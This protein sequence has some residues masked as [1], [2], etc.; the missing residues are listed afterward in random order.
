MYYLKSRDSFEPR[1]A[2]EKWVAVHGTEISPVY[3]F[4]GEGVSRKAMSKAA[5]YNKVEKSY[6]RAYVLC[7]TPMWSALHTPN[8]S[9]VDASLIYRK[10]A[11]IG[12][13]KGRP[14]ALMAA[15]IGFITLPAASS[16]KGIASWIDDL[17][18]DTERVINCCYLITRELN[19]A[20]YPFRIQT[21]RYIRSGVRLLKL[22]PKVTD[23]AII[24]LDRMLKE[25]KIG[26]IKQTPLAAAL[27]YTAAKEM[28]VKLQQKQV[29]DAF[30]VSE[31]GLRRFR[32][33]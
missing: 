10:C 18:I 1:D 7:F 5:K 20:S 23:R 30:H 13:T 19:M 6:W 26:R 21:R 33:K 31:R 17:E 9:R 25:K 24:I 27:V 14:T 2:L 22:D 16:I 4:K 12:L 29:A 28:G 3:P 32:G 11:K 8:Y 15:A